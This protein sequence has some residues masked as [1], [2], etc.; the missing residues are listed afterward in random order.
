MS[1]KD[2]IAALL[3][4]FTA[5]IHDKDADAAVALL[6]QDA[7]VYDLAPPLAQG[8]DQ[9]RDPNGYRMWF[10]TWSSPISSE[11]D[12]LHV[13]VGG[14]IAHA[15]CLRHM[16]GTKTDGERNHLWFRAT[17]CFRREDGEWRISHMHN[18]VPFAMDG[19]GKA[20]LDLKP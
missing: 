3:D 5:A 12:D 14:D 1:D 8:P 18:S 20:L 15:W 17:A 13:E 19:S 10:A 2:A 6:S 4:R 7:V 16:S 9:A 11:A